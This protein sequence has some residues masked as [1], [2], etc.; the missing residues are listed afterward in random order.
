MA[1]G[2]RYINGKRQAVKCS[3]TKSNGEPC[4]KWA[5]K[6][7]TVCP[8]HGASLPVVKKKAAERWE[9]AQ[10]M[11]E[12]ERMV[13]KGLLDER[14]RGVHPIEHLLDELYTSAQVVYVLGQMVG[15]LDKL[16]QYGGEGSGRQPHVLYGMWAEERKHHAKLAEMCLR[17]GVAERQI[18]IAERQAELMAGAIRNILLEL[19]VADHPQ[20]PAVVRKALMEMSAA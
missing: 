15:D 5:I 4:Q 6:G 20:A 9:R 16:D 12:V 18:Q 14:G 17:A 19:G 8:S 11:A 1:D 2:K 3:A 7:G 13:D 10:V